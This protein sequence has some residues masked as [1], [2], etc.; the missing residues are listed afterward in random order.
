[1][2]IKILGGVAKGFS[3]DAP[4][5]SF[6]RP[7]SVMLKRRLFDSIQNFQ[8]TTFFDICA[9]SGSIGLEALSRGAD[10]VVLIEKSPKNILV[11][12]KNAKQLMSK[13]TELSHFQIILGDFTKILSQ[14]SISSSNSKIILFFDPPYEQTELYEKF[15]K[16]L[17]SID[18]VGK[19]VIE[20][21]QQ[22][23]MTIPKFEEEFGNAEKIFKQGTSY[24]AIYNYEV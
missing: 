6:T 22:K 3:L 19:V 7:T 8:G 17:N 18:F 2:S 4:H 5:N 20:A 9:G 11:I 13:Y 10:K 15:F 21:C 24:F 14:E 1:M 12:K 16:L 23:T